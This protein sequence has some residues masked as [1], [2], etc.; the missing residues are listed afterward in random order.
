MTFVGLDL[1]K[2]YITACALDVTGALLGEVRRMPVSSDSLLEFLATFP[3]PVTVGMEATLYWQWLHDQL[4]HAGHSSRVADARQVKLIWQVRSKTDPIDARKLA[5]LLRVN[6]FPTVWIPDHDTRRR[7]Q[8]LHGRAFLVRQRTQIKNR[9]HG[10]LTA[11]NLLFPRSDLY[12]RA[13]RAWLATTPLSPMLRSQ[14]DR[15]LRLHDGLT[16]EIDQLDDE[17]KRLRRDHPAIT[18]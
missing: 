9:I 7:R 10:R 17:V 3:A 5:E 6:L 8:L 11:E 18:Q 12:G 16:T 2:R 4:E 14:V 15:L 1:H 13:G